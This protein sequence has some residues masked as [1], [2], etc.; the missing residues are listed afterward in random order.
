MTDTGKNFAFKIAAKRLQIVT[1][2]LLTVI[3]LSNGSIANSL[4]EAKT[5]RLAAIHASR[6]ERQTDRKKHRIQGST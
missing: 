3:A 5:Y 1:W 4:Y 6:T 2:L